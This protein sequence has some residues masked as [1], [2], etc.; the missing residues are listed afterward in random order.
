VDGDLLKFYGVADPAAMAARGEAP[1]TAWFKWFYPRERPVSGHAF[2][3]RALRD[4]ACGAASALELDV[5]GGD[6]VVTPEGSIFVIDVNAWP[7]FA[8]VRRKRPHRRAP[9]G[10]TAPTRA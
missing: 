10:A 4:I 5:W 8:L 2:D 1:S 3:A 7:S 9:D 6:A